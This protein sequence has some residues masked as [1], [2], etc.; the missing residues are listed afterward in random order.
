MVRRYKECSGFCGAL[1]GSKKIIY[2]ETE[3]KDFTLQ[4][5]N[6]ILNSF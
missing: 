2:N 1:N 3:N 6:T 5:S 4:S